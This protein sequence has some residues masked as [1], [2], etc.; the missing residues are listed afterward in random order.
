MCTECTHVGV[1][2]LFPSDVRPLVLLAPLCCNNPS[3]CLWAAVV[4]MY[5]LIWQSQDTLTGPEAIQ[6]S[7]GLASL[8]H[9]LGV[10]RLTTIV[11]NI[12]SGDV[13]L[14]ALGTSMQGKLIWHGQDPL[15]VRVEAVPVNSR[16]GNGVRSHL[17]L[18]VL[19]VLLLLFH[20]GLHA[21]Q[22][23][24]DHVLLHPREKVVSRVFQKTQK[25]VI[26]KCKPGGTGYV[27]N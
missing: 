12:Q 16:L 21:E 25:L 10:Q 23:H 2:L 8:K 22:P 15:H 5:S 1:A 24:G 20:S 7:K 18:E 6:T 26:C 19:L 9:Q 3:S 13:E 11:F 14:G 4:P 17:L 27:H